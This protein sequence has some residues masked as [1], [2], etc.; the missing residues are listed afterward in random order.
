MQAGVLVGS[1]RTSDPGR[2]A[3]GADYVFTIVCNIIFRIKG[4]NN[5]GD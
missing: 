3:T 4:A 2:M 5:I 1:I